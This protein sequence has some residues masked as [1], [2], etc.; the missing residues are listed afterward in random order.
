[1]F[2]ARENE[3]RQLQEELNTPAPG[4]ILIYGK[5]RVG[6]STLI[7]EAARS[8][9]G[10][11]IHHMCVQST[12]AGNLEML[13][14]S[15]SDALQLPMLSFSSL[16]DL[17]L[18]LGTQP[19]R[20]LLVLDEYSYYKSAGKQGEIDSVMQSV[21]DRLPQN[22]KLVL[23]GSYITVMKEL[24]DESNPLFGRFR[25]ILH[26][27]EMD[28]YDAA[29][30]CPDVPVRDKI[31]NYAVWG[32]S[33]YVLATIDYTATLEQNICRY[34][35]PATGILRV[36]I[37]SVMLREIQKAYDVRIL[38]ILGN[39][40]KRY[41]DLTSALGGDRG[42]LLDKQLKNLLGME[43]ISKVAP[44]NRPEDKKK[45]FYVISD[46]LMRFY[47]TYLF[48]RTSQITRL[49]E[50]A[51]YREYVAPSLNEFISRRFEDIACQYFA[52]LAH[53]GT[54][55][56][57]LDIGSYWYDDPVSRTN[58]EFDCVLRRA[59]SYDFYECKYYQS[60]MPIGECHQEEEQVRRAAGEMVG[61][62][63][64]LCSAGFQDETDQYD[65]IN[66]EM[67]YLDLANGITEAD[68][69]ND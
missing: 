1:M 43:T 35:L 48:G 5:R 62:I 21:I 2:L 59:D 4:A 3:L 55:T 27:R 41:S 57:V 11:Y 19:Q 61:R 42:G 65:L 45:Q 28:Y 38:E 33:P 39:G 16:P 7:D 40:K 63:G 31:A 14:R 34:L 52:R 26:L 18:F 64:F 47:F 29:L 30:F 69:G 13:C 24:M 46:N 68:C 15:V 36:Y 37:E 23:C 32:G 44:I 54:L 17:F 53:A 60:P 12:V 10:I 51:Y 66:G 58:G 22:I 9:D 49:G 6:K 50:T 8:F 67:L 56:G 20:I 25:L